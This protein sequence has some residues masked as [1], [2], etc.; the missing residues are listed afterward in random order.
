MIGA[1]LDLTVTPLVLPPDAK[2]LRVREL[3]PRL[4][5]RVGEDVDD[6]AV[7]TRPGFRITA[8]LMPAPLVALVEEFR[9]PSLVT[10]AVARFATAHAQ[11]P[12]DTIDLAFDALITLVE[13]RIL[14]PDGSD[15]LH[16]PEA[17]LAAGQAFAGVEVATLVRGLDDSEVYRGRDDDG[18]DV[19][20]K[21]GRAG[22]PEVALTLGREAN[23]LEALDGRGA[24][25]LRA[26]GVEDGRAFLVM[27]WCEGVPVAVAAQQARAARDRGALHRLAVRV[28]EAYARLHDRGVLHGDVHPGNLLVRDDGTVVLIDFGNAR[29]VDA[30]PG[31]D[32]ARTGIPQ[33]FDPAMAAALLAGEPPPVATVAAEQY[34]VAALIH[35]LVTTLAP[36]DAPADRQAL[37]RGLVADPLRP[38]VTRGVPAWP[39]LERVLARALE[40]DAPA[41]FATTADFA[42]ALAAARPPSRRGPSL[43]RASSRVRDAVSATL[44][45]A[46]DPRG[47]ARTVAHAWCALQA[48]IVFDDPVWLAQ[49]EV[50]LDSAPADDWR[51]HAVGVAVARAR[52]DAARERRAAEA[53]ARCAGGLAADDVAAACGAA[54]DLVHALPFSSGSDVLREWLG[55]AAAPPARGTGDQPGR[56]GLA[57]VWESL[58][59]YRATGDPRALIS[60][61]RALRRARP[62]AA[63]AAVAA[64]WF[65]VQQPET[66]ARP[67]FAA[68]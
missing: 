10:D 21:I 7:V 67:P 63:N 30:A 44:V 13:A 53:L 34:A 5:A 2:V 23:V 49:A 24:P 56:G 38:F 43:A 17:T 55:G 57:R 25:R 48:A 29:P 42:A 19:A 9:R 36:I 12:D 61:T 51:T 4:R 40:K 41:R 15:D 22:R 37:L 35:L 8:R 11:S 32:P 54:R 6:H 65:A 26:A 27:D 39:S 20:L 28:A 1:P 68:S 47:E 45:E 50:L 3:A 33:F 66:P 59:R 46:C 31:I 18:R 58:E 62:R 14:V 52:S 60:A 16:V 64:A